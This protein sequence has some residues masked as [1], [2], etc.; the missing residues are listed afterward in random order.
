MVRV[1]EALR[2]FRGDSTL[3]TWIYRIATNTVLDK[4]RSPAMK[5][6]GRQS[7]STGILTESEVDSAELRI[8]IEEQT[9]SVDVTLIR[10]EMNECIRE[11]I[12]RLPENYKTVMVLSEL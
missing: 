3:S 9:P 1:S 11:F 5:W 2:D 10:E 12:D 4:L 7:G 8:P 6:T